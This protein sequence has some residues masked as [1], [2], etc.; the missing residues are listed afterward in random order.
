MPREQQQPN[1]DAV[2]E[3]VK[4]ALAPQDQPVNESQSRETAQPGGPSGEPNTPSEPQ[5][6][7]TPEEQQREIE[8]AYRAARGR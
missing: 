4:T 3:A 2:V 7:L 8:R 5:Q 1:V 6:E